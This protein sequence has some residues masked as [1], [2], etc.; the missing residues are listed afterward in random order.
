MAVQIFDNRDFGYY[1]VTID[2]PD[3]RRA[4]FSAE[5][6]APLRFDKSLREA[7]EHI[8]ETHGEEVYGGETL[9][10]NRQDI[11][12]WCENNDIT[13]NAKNRAKLL[14]VKFWIKL[15]DLHGAGLALMQAIGT[16][17][18]DDFNAFKAQ[19]DAAAKSAKLALSAP[20]KKAILNAVSWYDARAAK[21]IKKK[22]KLSGGKLADLLAHLGCEESGLADFG[23]YKQQE[24]GKAESLTGTKKGGSYLTYEHNTDLRDAESVPLSDTI[25]RYFLAEVKPHVEE[26]WINLDSVKIGYEISFNK[27]FYRHK[28]LRSLEAVTKD[29]LQLEEQADG[30]MA[31]ILGLEAKA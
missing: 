26:A 22:L 28:P 17:E 31:E 24:A 25:H 11:L 12:K 9:Q 18:S 21:V 7:M 16:D 30:L 10:A 13:L 20:E 27:Y 6:L 19:V 29:I 4:Q 2:R 8:F 23:Y 14:D 15:R 1:K 3:R 5:R